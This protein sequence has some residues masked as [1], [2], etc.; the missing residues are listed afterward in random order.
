MILYQLS[1][2]MEERN[3]LMKVIKESQGDVSLLQ[4]RKDQVDEQ[5]KIQ[6]ARWMGNNAMTY[7]ITLL[8]TSTFEYQP[9]AHAM[10][11]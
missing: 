1:K 4:H 8:D 2:W 9:E 7:D 10:K 3:R 11:Y 5:M 6:A